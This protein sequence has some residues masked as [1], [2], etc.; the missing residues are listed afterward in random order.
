MKDR[1]GECP[2]DSET[3]LTAKTL[4]PFAKFLKLIGLEVSV[5]KSERGFSACRRA[6]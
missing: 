3:D 2:N 4:R 1:V 6:G 5:I